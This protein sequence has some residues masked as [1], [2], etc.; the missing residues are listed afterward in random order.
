MA[1]DLDHRQIGYVA[2]ICREGSLGRAANAL[3]VAQPTLSKVIARLEDRLG[4]KLFDRSGRGMTPTIFAEHIARK[5]ELVGEVFSGLQSDLHAMAL[6]EA[7]RLRIGLGPGMSLL[8]RTA[9]V[10]PLFRRLP[11]LKLE[12]SSLPLDD[13]FRELR[14][15]RFEFILA[16][17]SRIRGDDDFRE[18]PLLDDRLAFFGAR[19]HRLAG[20]SRVSGPQL[21]EHPCAFPYLPP[22]IRALFPTRL[23]EAQAANLTAFQTPDI[24]LLKEIVRHTDAI[25]YSL[26]SFLTADIAAGDLVEIQVSGRWPIASSF[27]ASSA[28]W[29]SPVVRTIAELMHEACG[30]WQAAR[31]V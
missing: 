24:L 12:V 8:F 15:G 23:S 10:E 25:S 17:P 19:G 16:N 1:L 6:G 22:E 18:T 28:A 27:I 31:A 20:E 26:H 21:L 30:G 9:L 11:R 5:A 29:H 2:A 7:G 14:A 13:L 4:V 3:G